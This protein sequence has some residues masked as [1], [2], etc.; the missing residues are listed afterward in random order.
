MAGL[1]NL[2]V[3]KASF[4]ADVN[5]LSQ[6]EMEKEHRLKLNEAEQRRLESEEKFLAQ[7]A[8]LTLGRPP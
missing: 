2:M 8:H 1:T 5:Y 7:V 6:A 4:P 3:P